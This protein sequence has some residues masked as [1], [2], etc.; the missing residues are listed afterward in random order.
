MSK[1]RN[2]NGEGTI[3]FNEARQTWRAQIRWVDSAGKLHS[4]GWRDNSSML[5][6]LKSIAAHD[7]V[8]PAPLIQ[9][10]IS[11]EV[12]NDFNCSHCGHRRSNA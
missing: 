10:N 6:N 3:Y 7:A 1:S 5:S 2:S 8:S 12:S 11:T 9:P 4:K